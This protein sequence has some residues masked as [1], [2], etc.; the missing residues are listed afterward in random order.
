MTLTDLIALIAASGTLSGVILYVLQKWFPTRALSASVIKTQKEI[1]QI[2]QE[3][4][5]K[6]ALQVKKW[7]DD[8]QEIKDKNEEALAKKDATIST[9]Q[10]ERVIHLN[11]ITVLRL[12]LGQCGKAHRRLFTRI[13]VPYWECDHDGKLIYANGAWLT[14][15]GIEESR[16]IGEGWLTS[17]RE[18]DK[19]R[20]LVD[21]YSRVVDESDG[22][23]EFT[24]KNAITGTET[25]VKAI[26]AVKFNEES[27]VYKIIGVT[28][29]V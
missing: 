12:K 9:L 28:I 6:Y 29:P 27:E 20:L 16:A 26:Y 3:V 19:K 25:K 2:E 11:E 14:L 1:E 23:L 7:L 24:V 13:H 8:L 10:D 17:I 18:E 21:W 5:S 15:F 4:E 22:E